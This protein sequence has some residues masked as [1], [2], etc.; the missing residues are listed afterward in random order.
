MRIPTHHRA[1][2]QFGATSMTPL[3]DIVF[4]LLIFFIC[5][6]IGHQRE[7]IL[8]IDFGAG[9][10]AAAVEIPE[11]PLGEVWIRLQR[12]QDRTLVTIEGTPYPDWDQVRGVLQALGQ[13]A[14]DIPVILD[15]APEVPMEDVIRVD[16]AC[17]GAHFR[18]V[19]FA[20]EAPPSK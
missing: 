6:S 1:S 13:T 14:A 4:Q 8:P 7:S 2:L 11:R 15:I 9:S 19:S 3:I 16:D 18:S 17:R 12:E 5:A 10:L 20:A